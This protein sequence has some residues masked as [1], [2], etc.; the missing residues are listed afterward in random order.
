[1]ISIRSVIRRD[2][3]PPRR[4]PGLFSTLNLYLMRES[5]PYY[6]LTLSLLTTLIFSQQLVRQAEFLTVDLPWKFWLY[7]LF[8]TLPGVL[9]ITV[10]FSCLMATLLAISRLVSD[11]EI[12]GINST[13]ISSKLISCSFL[14]L[15]GVAVLVAVFINFSLIPTS[16]R[17]LREL[18]NQVI[19][20]TLEYR[21]KPR[22]LTT[23]FSNHVV[24]IKEADKLT[25][26]WSGVFVV[27][28][29]SGDESLILSAQ[30]GQLFI[31]QEDQSAGIQLTNGL[32]VIVDKNSTQP[33][34]VTRFA[35]SYTKLTDELQRSETP[36]ESFGKEVQEWNW[37]VLTTQLKSIPETSPEYR[38][39]E[40]EW[41]KRAS[42]AISSL[43][44][45][46]V[47]ILIGFSLSRR[48]GRT[49]ILSIGFVV[50]IIYYLLIVAG[51]NLA[52]AGTVSP[53]VGLLGG[54][55]LILLLAVTISFPAFHYQRPK[56][57]FLTDDGTLND[58]LRNKQRNFPGVRGGKYSSS[59]NALSLINYLIISEM[60][61]STV[62]SI[63]I[64]TVTTLVFTL[65][66]IVPSLSKNNVSGQTA[67]SYLWFLSPQVLYYMAPFGVALGIMT[68][69]A[70]LSRTG[71]I[72]A[73]FAHGLST[74][75]VIFP[76]L[77]VV[78][79]LIAGLYSLSETL[80]P[81]AN[82]EQDLRYNQIKGRKNEQVV[83]A[84][85]KRWVL[86]ADKTLYSFS[87][88][89]EDNQL[90]DTTAYSLNGADGVLCQVAFAARANQIGNNLWEALDADGGRTS[91]YCSQPDQGTKTAPVR[92]SVSD[93]KE[94]FRRVVNE[95]SK[96]NRSELRK[97]ISQVALSGREATALRID[98][99]K[100]IGSPISCLVLTFIVMPFCLTLT[101]KNTNSKV[102]TGVVLCIAFWIFSS[103]LE[104]LG[105][106]SLLPTWLSVFGAHI[107]FTALGFYLFLRLRK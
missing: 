19:K 80:L 44:L 33:K 100:K 14:T 21:I 29:Q 37:S 103:L 78:G 77:G 93:G 57:G 30:K 20:R 16:L 4:S 64:L 104:T 51:Q 35:R 28:Q 91:Y 88:I 54:N 96:M 11:Q 55:L 41:Y 26:D 10:P 68:V 6:L 86:S 15:S 87:S 31:H 71:Q 24:F 106:Q 17:N 107:I 13:G 98:Y 99:A 83:L 89:G 45:T 97:Y 1:M 70:V 79:I 102:A 32:A 92:F 43:A 73:I 63:C 56:P 22:T 101:R 50:A 75:R 36:H 7:I 62:L 60:F 46:F 65:F 34:S 25:G 61:K 84:L 8:N 72:T 74:I 27:K 48:I 90:H 82:R 23:S 12:I 66:D 5:V 105:K 38:I 95:S 76:V 42:L 69:F 9:I 18:R 94:L 3:N 39:A 81:S 40:I 67:F 85:G 58:S 59:G 47:A 53:I 2:N 52:L 49:A